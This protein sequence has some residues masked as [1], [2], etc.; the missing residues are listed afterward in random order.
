ML[1]HRKD[2][3]AK[4]WLGQL[5]YR[6]TV[7]CG[8]HEITATCVHLSL[9]FPPKTQFLM[10]W[11]TVEALEYT[12][13][14]RMPSWLHENL[15]LSVGNAPSSNNSLVSQ[16][17]HKSNAEFNAP[18]FIHS[19]VRI[20]EDSMT[21]SHSRLGPHVQ[22]ICQSKLNYN[23]AQSPTVV[24]ETTITHFS[25][26]VFKPGQL[27]ISWKQNSKTLPIT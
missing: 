2:S 5:T 18:G 23:Q 14:I 20:R 6:L 1:S 21:W 10:G 16:Q 11:G 24:K 7:Y 9:L 22:F 4:T 26:F 27:L 25:Q 12:S 13:Y 8:S 19:R 3:K 17:E 15:W